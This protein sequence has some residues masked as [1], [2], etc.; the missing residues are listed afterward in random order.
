MRDSTVG[1][2]CR[3][4]CHTAGVDLCGA[5]ARLCAPN[6]ALLDIS[7]LQL[8][9]TAECFL[10]LHADVFRLVTRLCHIPRHKKTGPPAE[11]LA[12]IVF[13]PASHGL[14][15]APWKGKAW[16]PAR[17]LPR[18]RRTTPAQFARFG[19]EA[20]SACVA[21]CLDFASCA[22]T[23]RPWGDTVGHPT[24]RALE[25]QSSTR[26]AARAHGHTSSQDDA[27]TTPRATRMLLSTR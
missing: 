17:S 12:P 20:G 26:A 2:V 4:Q 7:G 22:R 23:A 13:L 6:I 9:R 15:G 27:K 8:G 16:P 21:P 10:P 11:R 1:R 18:R 24:A 14:I 25:A 5:C 19:P 3:R